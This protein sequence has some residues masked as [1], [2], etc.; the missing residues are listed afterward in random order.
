MTLYDA[1]KYANAM[2][3]NE[4]YDECYE[5]GGTGIGRTHWDCGTTFTFCDSRQSSPRLRYT[6][7]NQCDGYRL[8]TAYE[9]EIA[10]RAGGGSEPP[11]PLDG[12]AQHRGRVLRVEEVAPPERRR[13]RDPPP[14]AYR[15]V[16][17]TSEHPVAGL[18]PNRWG[19]YD[20]WGNVS[21]FVYG[22]IEYEVDGDA[23]V[24]PGLVR[25]PWSSTIGM[26]SARG[27]S[28]DD[29]CTNPLSSRRGFHGS[30]MR[31]T[32]TGFRLVRTVEMP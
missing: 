13:R 28:F 18:S 25:D 27:C 14:A 5:I 19:L 4:G 12:Y 24:S 8:P 16:L 3:R 9:W 20:L 2:S 6:Y 29:P 7:G 32:R 17:V 26:A 15:N 1:L 30:A 21:E 10:A 11:S 22:V 23:V 31:S